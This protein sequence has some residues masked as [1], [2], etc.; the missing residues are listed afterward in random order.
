MKLIE[1]LYEQTRA[2]LNKEKQERAAENHQSN[3]QMTEFRHLTVKKSFVTC[4]SKHFSYFSEQN[5]SGKSTIE[6]S[7][8]DESIE[9]QRIDWRISKTFV[10]RLV[11]EEFAG[12]FQSKSQNFID[13]LVVDH[14]N[15]L[16]SKLDE[17]DNLNK[18]LDNFVLKIVCWWKRSQVLL[19]N[20]V[21]GRQSRRIIQ[22]TRIK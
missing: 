11:F 9:N 12:I 4:R 20:L 3:Q 1:Q 17:I 19:W 14:N 18:R 15:E 7:Q 21:L 5:R 22:F 8:C 2:E 16:K 13:S 6:V 10:F